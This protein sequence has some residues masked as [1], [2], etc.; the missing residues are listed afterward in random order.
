MGLK[1]PGDITPEEYGAM[2]EGYEQ[3]YEQGRAAATAEQAEHQQTHANER[4]ALSLLLRQAA[5]EY[6]GLKD[7]DYWPSDLADAQAAALIAAGVRLGKPQE[8]GGH[9]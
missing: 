5:R 2:E 9:R 7:G 1:Y 8:G 4:T 6:L 3:G